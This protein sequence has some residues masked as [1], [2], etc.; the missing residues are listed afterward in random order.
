MAVLLLAVRSSR[1]IVF[2]DLDT[3]PPPP[4]WSASQAQNG[5]LGYSSFPVS[6]W[7]RHT[8]QFAHQ[9][10]IQ[11]DLGRVTWLRRHSAAVRL[12]TNGPF[13]QVGVGNGRSGGGV[14]AF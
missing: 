5:A 14:N 12:G 11:R 8:H 10:A 1:G 9:A 6:A 13:Q 4:F 2:P 3:T 7:T